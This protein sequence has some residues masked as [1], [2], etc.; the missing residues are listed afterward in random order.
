MANYAHNFPF[1]KHPLNPADFPGVHRALLLAL[2]RWIAD[3]VP[4]P[5]SQF[6][7]AGDGT[8]VVAD[9]ASYGF[10]AIPGVE[11]LGLVNA[12]SELD[13]GTQPPRPIAGHD[14]AVTVPAVDEDGNE[15]AGIRVPEVAVPRGT[16]TGW[17]PRRAGY[18]EDELIALGAYL[19][20]ARTRKERLAAGDARL[21]LEERYPTS[22][23]YIRKVAEAA[24]ALLDQGLLLAEDVDRI[25][26]AA[27]ERA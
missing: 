14:Y 11:Y 22:G 23:D 7:A 8:L 20:F 25:V 4:P 3:D 15:V 18:A 12:L 9:P 1:T 26:D 16:H 21:S 27:R 2:D 6:P 19:P 5:T 13:Y 17:A 10:P 24:R